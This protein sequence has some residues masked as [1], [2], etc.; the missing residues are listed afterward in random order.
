LSILFSRWWTLALLLCL[1][2]ISASADFSA[3]IVSRDDAGAQIGASGK[4]YVAN[5]KV[6]I[7]TPEA[8]AGFFLMD[9]QAGTALFVR[10]TQ[11]IFTDARQSS[12]LTRIFIPV[13]PNDPCPQWQAAAYSAGVHG[14]WHC[15][16]VGTAM[17]DGRPTTECRVTSVDRDASRGWIDAS[18]GFPIRVRM[19][20]GTSLTLEHIRVAAQSPELF[21]IPSTYRR[22]DPHALIERI[23][24]SDVWV[25]P[26]N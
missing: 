4:L 5:G 16:P 14:E 6:R 18:I 9:V 3:D 11:Q 24:H 23:K 7:E 22:L 15:D 13:D 10:P 21:V 2:R 25:E 17:I 12:R 20:D 1:A 19:D 26:P 8:A